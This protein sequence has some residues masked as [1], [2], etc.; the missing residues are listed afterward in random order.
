MPVPFLRGMEIWHR[1]MVRT[2][3]WGHPALRLL[4]FTVIVDK[5]YF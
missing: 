1:V 3:G 5:I 4:R 2:A